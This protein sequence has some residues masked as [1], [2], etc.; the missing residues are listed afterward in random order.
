MC[1]R[2][3]RESLSVPASDGSQSN[4]QSWLLL[5]YA[6]HRD[7]A[8]LEHGLLWHSFGRASSRLQ[9]ASVS[10]CLLSWIPR[11]PGC[12]SSCANGSF[13][14]L[15]RYAANVVFIVLSML[16]NYSFSAP[17]QPLS[18]GNSLPPH[19]GQF[20]VGESQ[21]QPPHVSSTGQNDASQGTWVQPQE[22][23]AAWPS[24]AW[25]QNRN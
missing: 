6:V 13:V 1:F 19:F 22:S 25:N 14:H 7:S 21:P 20:A 10:E 9:A 18:Y 3:S 16:N 8:G 12:S 5:P 17:G 15:H 2:W 11:L 4:V 24:P 23:Q